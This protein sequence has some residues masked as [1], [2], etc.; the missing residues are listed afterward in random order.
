VPDSRFCLKTF[1]IQCRVYNTIRHILVAQYLASYTG[2]TNVSIDSSYLFHTLMPNYQESG[3]NAEYDI[4]AR[5]MDDG[6]ANQYSH[7]GRLS[8]VK[9]NLAL[10]GVEMWVMVEPTS[11]TRT[12]GRT[13]N[14]LLSFSL[15]N[16]TNPN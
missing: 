12:E 1:F 8:R 9:D 6:N 15:S 2:N 3:S 13:T 16:N 7:E 5:V 11:G 4:L 10:T 14:L